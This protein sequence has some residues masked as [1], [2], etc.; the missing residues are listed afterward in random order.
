MVTR[1]EFKTGEPRCLKNCL[2]KL[3]EECKNFR[4]AKQ[5][6]AQIVKSPLLPTDDQ[7]YLITRLLFFC[8][9]SN[10]GSFTYASKVFRTIKHPE[11]RAYNIMLRSYADLKDDGEDSHICRALLIYREM[12][13]NGILPKN[14]TFPFLLKDCTRRLDETTGLGIHA[15]VTKFGFYDDIFVG[16]SLINLYMACRLLNNARKL[17]DEMRVRDIVTWNSMIIGFLRNGELDNAMELF[18]RMSEKNI[19]TWN[20]IITGLVQGGRPKESL[21]LFHQMQVSSED[22]MVEPDKFTIAS[23]L[24]ACAQLGSID[25]GQWVHSYLRRSGLDCDVVLG[26]AL[27]NMYGKCGHADQAVEIFKEMTRKDASAWTAMISVFALHGLGE[28]AFDCFL[29]ME[30]AGVKPNHVTFVGLLSACAHSGLVEKGRWCFDMMKNVYSI[31]PQ[32]YHYACMVDI[33]SRTKL[34]EEAERLIRDMPMKP[35]VYVWGSLLGGC[36][37]HGN[38]DLGEKVAIHL[39]NLEPHNHAFY[40]NLCDIYAKAGQFDAA[41]RV[42]NL[43]KERGIQKEIPGC[44]MIEICGV[45]HEFSAGVSLNLPTEIFL[46]VNELNNQMKLPGL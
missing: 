39:I 44:S 42:R 15:Q 11:I 16:N 20:S 41:K 19:I 35:D 5:I 31:E 38:I 22:T 27:V 4:E 6:H 14:L 18:T 12:L 46:I 24:S 29:E 17:F 21:Q 45:V 25:H 37:M 7:Y 23:V 32:V 9:F 33:L 43:M 30:K 3:I 36:Q 26:T 10:W 40:M 28:K 13:R 1:L 2:S 8:A 34:F